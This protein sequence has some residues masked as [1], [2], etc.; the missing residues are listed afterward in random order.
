MEE[1]KIDELELEKEVEKALDD[2]F[3]DAQ[4]TELKE[5][6]I[7]GYSLL[8]PVVEGEEAFKRDL[9]ELVGEI[10]TIEWEII[11]EIAE[12]AA[13]K[14]RRLQQYK[15][16]EENLRL[17]RLLEN[18]LTEVSSPEKVTA[19]KLEI[20]K[21]AGDL[22]YKHNFENL[23][24][25]S[26]VAELEKGLESLEPE[27]KKSELE[28]E[29]ELEVPE[30]PS[31][32]EE[33]TVSTSLSPS[34]PRE[35]A[36]TSPLLSPPPEV[37]ALI[38]QLLKDYERLV[39]IDE[40]A[41]LGRRKALRKLLVK[42]RTELRE[43][44]LRV[45]KNYESLLSKKEEEIRNFISS[46]EPKKT[47]PD[48]KEVLWCRTPT[49][50]LI[51]PIE[52]VAFAGDIEEHWRSHLLEGLFPLKL[53]KGKGLWARLFGKVRPKLRGPLAEKE[54][55]ELQ[56]M[57]F[58]TNKLLTHENKLVLLWRDNHSL[59]LLVEDFKLVT[60]DTPPEWTAAEPPFLA[61]TRL[62]DEEA[63]L[64]SVTRA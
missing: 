16:D 11:P 8:E 12:K 4:K 46:K 1:K 18:L 35:E 39:A 9:E 47:L 49:R 17:I 59:A 53:L 19:Q 44:L 41:K 36:P 5:E 6:E 37:E 62:G 42:A 21:K 54:E 64:F 32:K 48:L 43:T 61:K 26:E 22:L 2:I 38:K 34:P 60:F 57:V 7:E 20:L 23:E 45:D 63:Y 3:K 58:K 52:E 10:L 31:P 56:N 13:E 40:L 29:L 33:P 14:C 24:V 25:A 55:K 28:L 50:S 30:I 27:E 15:L 51:I